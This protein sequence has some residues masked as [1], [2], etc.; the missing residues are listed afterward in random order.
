[1]ARYEQR[2]ASP[3]SAAG[4]RSHIQ[5]GNGSYTLDDGDG[6]QRRAIQV[7]EAVREREFFLLFY[8]SIVQYIV[9]L[10]YL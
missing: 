9:V 2:P 5:P 6:L 7:S 4:A 1:M 10:F 3:S 8:C